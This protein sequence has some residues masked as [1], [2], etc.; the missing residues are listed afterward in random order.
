MTMLWKRKLRHTELIWQRLH[1]C[2][3]FLKL[4]E[5]VGLK[6]YT[7]QLPLQIGTAARLSSGQ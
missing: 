6:Y 4:T 3:S 2:V 7:S 1:I 5:A